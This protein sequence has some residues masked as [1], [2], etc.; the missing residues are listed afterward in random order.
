MNIY[1][2]MPRVFYDVYDDIKR[3]GHNEYWLRGGRGS[4]KSSFAALVIIRGILKD[5]GANAIVY[6]RVAATVKDSVYAKL[7]WAAEQMGVSGYF[8]F[9]RS[10]LEIEYVPTGQRILFRGADDPVKSKSIA[11]TKGYFAYL[12]FEELSEFRCAADIRTIVQSVLRGSGRG[13]TICTYNPPASAQSWVNAEALS[14]RSDRL[15][16]TS[17]YKDVPPEWLG[18][19][20]LME[21]EALKSA[22]ERAYRNEYLGEVTGS[23]GRVFDNLVLR[24]ITDEEIN[25]VE[26]RFMGLDFGFA[27]DPDAFTLAGYT[28]RTKT[29][30]LISEF[31]SARNSPAALAK[32]V[33]ARAGQG[34]V[35]CDSA[36]PRMIAELKRCGINA[37]AVKKGPGS[38][39]FS[40]RWLETLGA[41]VID[42]GRT[43]KAAKEFALYEYARD[44]NGEFVN[45]YPDGNDHTIDSVRYALMEEMSARTAV[46]RADIY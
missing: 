10:P 2:L 40:Y 44:K 33:K 29:L 26:R 11:L 34:R 18:E 13:I 37:A 28:R 4:C 21:A 9:R 22:N 42:P 46:T 32:E 24:S 6:R 45:E 3:G 23:G 30:Y 5:S 36:E 7:V 14:A 39:E 19:R 20:F 16:H 43:P 12:W 17:T 35:F 38:R 8:R 27:A 25:A 15:V 1:S 41:I 31:V